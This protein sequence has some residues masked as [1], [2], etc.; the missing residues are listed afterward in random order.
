MVGELKPTIQSSF[1]RDNRSPEEKVR[2]A[3]QISESAVDPELNKL[4]N[5]T[6]IAANV[7]AIQPACEEAA[8]AR[9]IAALTAYTKAW[10]KKLNC[11][12]PLPILIMFCGEENMSAAAAA[13]STPVD[14]RVKDA[15]DAAFDRGGILQSDFPWSVRFDVLHFAGPNLWFEESAVCRPLRQSAGRSR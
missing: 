12:R 4:R 6:L 1:G 14:K 3:A 13:F 9:L 5:E 7:Y 8:K 10:Q 15:L 2:R 11:F